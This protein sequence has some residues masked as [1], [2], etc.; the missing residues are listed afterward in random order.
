MNASRLIYLLWS[1]GNQK[2]PGD[3]NK[4]RVERFEYKEKINENEPDGCGK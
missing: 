4:K 1:Q 3:L 2:P